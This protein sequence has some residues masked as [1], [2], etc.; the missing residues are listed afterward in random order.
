[1]APSVDEGWGAFIEV[2]QKIGITGLRRGYKVG[3]DV[4]KHHARLPRLQGCCS[5]YC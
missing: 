1:V 4:P 2:E 3:G 5:S